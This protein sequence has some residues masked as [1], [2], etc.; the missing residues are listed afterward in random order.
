MTPAYFE[1]ANKKLLKPAKMTDEECEPLWVYND[2]E[3]SIS[4]WQMT[5]GERLQ[6]LLWGRVWLGVLAGSSQPP[7][8]FWCALTPFQTAWQ[9]L[10]KARA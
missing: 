7:V 5:W 2:G 6:A 9:Y 4:C 8:R 1:K 3:E 10:R